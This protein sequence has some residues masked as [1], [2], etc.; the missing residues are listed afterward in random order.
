MKPTLEHQFLPAV[1]EIQETPPS[2][3]GRKIIWLIIALFVST[4]IW[5]ILGKVDIVAI[6]SGKIIPNGHVKVIQ[7]LEIGT[8]AAIHVAEGQEVQKGDILIE[9]DLSAI[10]AEIAQLSSEYVFVEQ[11]GRRLQWLVEQQNKQAMS[12]DWQDPVLRS[13]WQEYQDRLI[14]LQSEKNKRQ[15]EHAAVQQQADKLAAILPIISQRSA[16]EKILV[17][18][19]LFPRQQYLQTEQQRLIAYYDLKSQQ[20]RVDELKQTLSEIDAR[21]HHARSEFAKNNLE[22]HEESE[23][24]RHILEQEMIKTRT[25]LK[26]QYL[27]APIDGI[28]QQLMMHTVGGIVTPAQELMVI[29]PQNGQL[30]IEAYVENKDIGFVQEGQVAAIKLDAF[31]FTKFGTLEGEIINLSDDAVTDDDKGLIYKARVSLKQKNMQVEGK[32]V[33]LSPGMAVSV[34]I[35][36]GQRRLIEF[37]LA[38]L[39]KFKDES[40]RER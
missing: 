17:D 13:Q 25:R 14:T 30:E 35:K 19:K 22:K 29:V 5:G 11:Q 32:L 20:N 36:T 4:L 18:K 8:V 16:N 27:R 21:M 1:L 7:P 3:L 40:I 12:S 28:V 9:L 33:R 15:A 6:A 2:P 34:E 37:F 10:N 31:P 39:M 38:P 23:R 26:A 24:R